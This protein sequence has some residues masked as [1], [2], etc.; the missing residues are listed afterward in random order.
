VDYSPEAKSC[1]VGNLGLSHKI[2]LTLR[3]ISHEFTMLVDQ[4]SCDQLRHPGTVPRAAS[5]PGDLQLCFAC[6][7]SRPSD[8]FFLFFFCC[9]CFFFLVFFFLLRPL[10]RP[11]PPPLLSLSL[12]LH[13][14]LSLLLPL[15]LSPSLSLSLS[16][17]LPLASSLSLLCQPTSLL[18]SA[19]RANFSIR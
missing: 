14:L 16:L 9:C 4:I 1:N 12:P 10:V 18:S 6:C 17:P 19:L 7:S 5:Q 3:P 13:S 8:F 15:P 11:P 2:N